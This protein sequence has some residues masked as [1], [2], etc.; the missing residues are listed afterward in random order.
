MA[1]SSDDLARR[2]NT[3]RDNGIALFVQ[4]DRHDLTASHIAAT[5]FAIEHDARVVQE[6]RHELGDLNNVR[7]LDRSSDRMVPQDL[8]NETRIDFGLLDAEDAA[9]RD[10]AGQ[11]VITWCKERDIPL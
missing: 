3:C 7:S 9:V 6:S 4:T 11:G 8:L 2:F 10:N 1:H 5:D